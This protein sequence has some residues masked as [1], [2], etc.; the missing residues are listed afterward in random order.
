MT[1]SAQSQVRTIY[2]CSTPYNSDFTNSGLSELWH[3]QELYNDM[4]LPIT[5]NASFVEVD[6]LD[7]NDVQF[8]SDLSICRRAAASTSLPRKGELRY[9]LYRLRGISNS[10]N[11]LLFLDYYLPVRQ[12]LST[13]ERGSRSGQGPMLNITSG[14]RGIAIVKFNGTSYTYVGNIRR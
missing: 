8:V 12:Q 2:D 3:G 5:N 11:S 6:Q 13:S 7:Y 14:L 10:S 9:S 4:L 1:N